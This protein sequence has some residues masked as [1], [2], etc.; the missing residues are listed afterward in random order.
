[1]IYYKAFEVR[2]TVYVEIEGTEDTSEKNMEQDV[3]TLLN[4]LDISGL[5]V[6]D[7]NSGNMVSISGSEVLDVNFDGFKKG[8]TTFEPVTLSKIKD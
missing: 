5:E 2:M 4:N 7:H 1:M 3:K 6:Y 8:V